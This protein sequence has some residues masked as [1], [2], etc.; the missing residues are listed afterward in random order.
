MI[1]KLHKTK[2]NDLD[3]KGRVVIAVNAFGNEDSDGDISVNGSFA[4]TLK[5]N[6][7]RVKWFLNHNRN[8]LLGVP[9]EGK[10]EGAYLKMTAQLNMEKQVSRDVYSDYKLYAEHGKT[11]EHSIGVDAIKRDASDSHKV[12]EW[13]LW[14]FS[15]LTAW[16]A[17][18]NTPLLAI[19][20]NESVAE[21]IAFLEKALKVKEY[22]DER[23]KKIEDT[24]AQLVKEQKGEHIVTCPYCGKEFDYN[25]LREITAETQV[26][27]SARRYAEW[28]LN[29]TVYDEMQKLEP[30]IQTQV[31]QIIESKKDI[32]S[33]VAYVR[34]PQ[35]WASVT[36]AMVKQT[37]PPAGTLQKEES[38]LATFNLKSIHKIIT[39]V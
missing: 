31:M 27:E 7:G 35:C 20:S 4:K 18:E 24:L 3:E 12:T 9:I 15:T 22:S 2:I 32:D 29:D 25:S 26:L 28:I 37:E 30:E 23:L 8:L 38:R 36:R 16:G 6:F 10:E 17:N 21:K 13:K 33:F 19:K 1:Q 39:K 14:E 34:C 5:E 11:L